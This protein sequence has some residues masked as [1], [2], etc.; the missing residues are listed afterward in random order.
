MVQTM[1]SATG[2]GCFA[3]APLPEISG[4]EVGRNSADQWSHVFL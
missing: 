1:Q 3:T 2:D 4:D